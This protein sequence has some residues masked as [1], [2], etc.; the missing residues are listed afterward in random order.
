MATH[1]PHIDPRTGERR[2]TAGPPIQRDRERAE[3]GGRDR[4][5]GSHLGDLTRETVE[6]VRQEIALAKAE[7]TEKAD[8]AKRGAIELATGGAVLTGGLLVL[9][10]AAVLLVGLLVPYWASALI[11]GG[12]VTAIGAVLLGKGKSDVNPK[13]LKPERSVQEVQRTKRMAQEHV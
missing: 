12:V 6:L 1:D 2:E 3:Q 7:A 9:L 5:L 11:V 4:P 10:A 8:Q 13:N